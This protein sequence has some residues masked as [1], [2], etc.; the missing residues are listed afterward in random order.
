M[1]LPRG[2]PLGEIVKAFKKLAIRLHPDKSPEDTREEATVKFQALSNAKETLLTHAPGNMLNQGPT[3]VPPPPSAPPS[4]SRGVVPKYGTAKGTLG[5]AADRGHKGEAPDQVG[6][7]TSV[8][9]RRSTAE[10]SDFP[11]APTG[12]ASPTTSW[13]A[14]CA[15][16]GKRLLLLVW[17]DQG[18][19]HLATRAFSGICGGS[20]RS[21]GL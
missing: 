8:R 13:G 9:T 3:S 16:V 6:P 5:L 20:L 21:T 4:A 18:A 15:V 11:Y 10:E 17:V 7:G 2:A 14:D 12:P 19:P 1:E